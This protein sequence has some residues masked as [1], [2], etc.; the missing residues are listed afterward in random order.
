LQALD[1]YRSGFA[2]PL[3]EEANAN[4][5][6]R[7]FAKL[8][9]LTNNEALM[10]RTGDY[11]WESKMHISGVDGLRIRGTGRQTV[12]GLQGCLS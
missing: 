2:T 10:A 12:S 7:A 8:N 5:F 6:D 3:S 9:M 4:R 1:V 11:A